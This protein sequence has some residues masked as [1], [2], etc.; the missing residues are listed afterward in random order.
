M[1]VVG[2]PNWTRTY[3]EEKAEPDPERPRNR[4]N[5]QSQKTIKGEFGE[6]KINI[7]RDR[8]GAFEPL[9]IG[10]GQTRF[11]GFDDKILSLYA[12]G[13]TTRDVQAQLQD[14]YEVE[15]SHTL[16]SNVTAA[17]EEERKARQ[18]CSL[19]AI[20]PMVY[21]DAHVWYGIGQDNR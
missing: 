16:I 21:L 13:M 8:N 17:V 6:A 11:N 12:R 19:D 4:R 14:F 1:S 15:V 20:Y 2:W 7:P 9:L 18:N 3:E 5:G 10:K